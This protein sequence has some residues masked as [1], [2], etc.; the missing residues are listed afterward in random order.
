[1]V[2]DFYSPSTEKWKTKHFA[3]PLVWT[4]RWARI[5][6]RALF[7]L[8]HGDPTVTNSCCIFNQ[9]E[10]QRKQTNN[11]TKRTLTCKL[12]QNGNTIT[13]K[14]L[15]T[16]IKKDNDPNWSHK[17]PPY[18][19]IS[20]AE[21]RGSRWVPDRSALGPW[22]PAPRWDPCLLETRAGEALRPGSGGGCLAYGPKPSCQA[23]GG[24]VKQLS[25]NHWG[26]V[27]GL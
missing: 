6:Q 10:F 15:A 25:I 12:S 19:T 24:E 21:I 22:V 8:R 17:F 20:A 14:Q 11:S 9:T 2:S 5:D 18:L 3:V 1:M 23:R 4:R 27:G 13:T 26:F 16:N 7:P